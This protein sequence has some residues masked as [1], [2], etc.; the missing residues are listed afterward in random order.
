MDTTRSC[1]GECAADNRDFQYSILLP[2][3][4][5]VHVL[6]L[7]IQKQWMHTVLCTYLLLMFVQ[8]F[9]FP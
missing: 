9:A 8:C 2:D 7:D 4:I 1:H 5:F 6:V 3:L